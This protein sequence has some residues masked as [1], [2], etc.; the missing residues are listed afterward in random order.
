MRP[1]PQGRGFSLRAGD[2]REGVIGPEAFSLREFPVAR[3]R[4]A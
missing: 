1:R 2:K 3:E 4:E